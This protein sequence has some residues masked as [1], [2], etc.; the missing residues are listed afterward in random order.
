MN[1]VTYLPLKGATFPRYPLFGH[2]GIFLGINFKVIPETVVVW[3]K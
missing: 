1:S 3:I 2:V